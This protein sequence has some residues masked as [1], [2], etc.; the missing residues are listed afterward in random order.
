MNLGTARLVAQLTDH[1]PVDEREQASILRFLAELERLPRPFEEHADPVHV[2]GS[3][4]VIGS[5]GVVLH[6][7]KRLGI[8]LQPGGHIESNEQP[9]E[10]AVRETVEELS[11]IHI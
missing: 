11:L 2:T 3:A 1:Q 6:R 10:A 8:W 4:I 9:W 7:H 5:R